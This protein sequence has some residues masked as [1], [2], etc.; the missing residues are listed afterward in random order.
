MNIEPFKLN[1]GSCRN[2]EST[3]PEIM[4][5]MDREFRKKLRGRLNHSGTG[6]SP[7][8][9]K[10]GFISSGVRFFQITKNKRPRHTFKIWASS[11][12]PSNAICS[13]APLTQT[14]DDCVA[15]TSWAQ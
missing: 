4:M 13:K 7:Q 9:F 15:A 10:R 3:V 8:Y 11:E 14:W 12:G 5:G 2:N 6:Q 1:F